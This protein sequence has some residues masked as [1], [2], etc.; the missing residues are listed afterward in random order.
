[1]PSHNILVLHAMTKKDLITIVSCN[2]IPVDRGVRGW[3]LNIYY[4]YIT[5]VIF[6]RYLKIK[7][8]KFCVE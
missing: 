6:K 4:M 8:R 5:S 1:M 3:E 7:R 2:F